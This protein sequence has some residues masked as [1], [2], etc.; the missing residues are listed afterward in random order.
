MLPNEYDGI[1]QKI[2]F[3]LPIYHFKVIPRQ[4]ISVKK[5]ETSATLFWDSLIYI[6][7]NIK[8]KFRNRYF[9]FLINGHKSLMEFEYAW[10]EL[11]PPLV[12]LETQLLLS[13]FVTFN[14]MT[15]YSGKIRIQIFAS[16]FAPSLQLLNMLTK[17]SCPVFNVRASERHW[18]IFR[19]LADGYLLWNLTYFLNFKCIWDVHDVIEYIHKLSQFSK[20]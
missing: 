20:F 18:F 7:V 10:D 12:L 2:L 19:Y 4:S 16:Y 14:A 3:S 13:M 11:I 5:I 1:E 8:Y 15:G 17:M 6:F 9:L